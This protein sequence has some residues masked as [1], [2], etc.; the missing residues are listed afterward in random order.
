MAEIAAREVERWPVGRAFALRRRA[1]ALTLEVIL[2]AV[3]GIRDEATLAEH[4]MLAPRLG[5]VSNLVVLLPGLRRNLGRFSPWGRFLRLRA[6]LDGLIYA[7]IARRRGD[8]DA[9]AR[10]DVLSLL[11]GARREDGSPMT[12]VELRDEL[13]TT[14]AAGH[15]T[16][17]T[18]LSWLFERLLRHPRVEQR[19]RAS[20][21]D[22]DES[23]LEAVIKETLRVRPVVVDVVRRLTADTE[24]AGWMIPAGTYV[25]PAIALVHLRPELYPDP[26]EFR[27]ERFLEGGAGGTYTWIPFGGGV[28]RCVGAA[29]AFEEMKVVTRTVLE[30]ARPRADRPRPE[31]QRARHVTVVPSRGGRVV[32]EE[33][34]RA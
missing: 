12:D 33:R 27:P 17:A 21:A 22:G 3:F 5:E 8:P 4:R 24:I 2:Q 13:V 23:Y 28:R 7:E 16:T 29:F 20:L 11:L 32:V 31:G 26:H 10:H 6:E 15:E 9:A 25:V 30:R 34:L 1:Q 18:G 19:L 14:I